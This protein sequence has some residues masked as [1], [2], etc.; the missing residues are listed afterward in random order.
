MDA[1]M[2]GLVRAA[3]KFD[4]ALGHAWSTYCTASVAWEVRRALTRRD[5]GACEWD[6]ESEIAYESPGPALGEAAERLLR[7]ADPAAAEAVRLYVVEG[8]SLKETARQLGVPA[9][10]ASE[11]VSAGLDAIREGLEGAQ[12]Y[13]TSRT[14][15]AA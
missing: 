9:R 1:A 8:W 4:E 3:A 15:T 12:S 5:S 10:V 11:L 2:Y 7:L 13:A 14:N 6:E